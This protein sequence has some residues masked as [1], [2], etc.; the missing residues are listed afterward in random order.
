M[1]WILN[2]IETHTL[3]LQRIDPATHPGEVTLGVVELRSTAQ[4]YVDV[5]GL[6]LHAL[7]SQE[8]RLGPVQGDRVLRLEAGATR[9]ARP[10][11][12]TGLYHMAMLFPTRASLGGALLRLVSSGYPIQGASDHGVSE[13]IYLAD[14]EGN[15]IELYADRSPSAWPRS[16]GTLAMV[17][18]PLDL[19]ALVDEARRD[20]F[21]GR[22][23]VESLRMGHVHLHVSHLEPAVAF[24]RDAL[25]LN[26]VQIYGGQAAFLA[27]GDY[28]HHIGINTWAGIG[29]PQ[30]APGAP[31]LREF[32]LLFPT[33]EA[34]RA[35]VSRLSAHGQKVEPREADHLTRDPSGNCIVLRCEEK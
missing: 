21:D 24:Y 28:H 9:A 33:H 3:E 2:R 29:A 4:F 19:D 8:A 10:A 34:L 1:R 32:T 17:T 20:G 22:D 18:D 23:P 12:A 7:D 35:T 31:G 30:P 27:A 11:R 13:A 14:P 15:G 16:H 26:L 5:L 25:G 6:T